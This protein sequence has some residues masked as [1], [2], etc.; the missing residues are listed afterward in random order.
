MCTRAIFSIKAKFQ[1]KRWFLGEKTH[2]I[3]KTDS[4]YEQSIRNRCKSLL[5]QLARN[6][7]QLPVD[8]RHLLKRKPNFTKTATLRALQSWAQR[9]N[10]GISQAKSG[11]KRSV[12]DI[13]NWFRSS[14]PK[15]TYT[16][17]NE[18]EIE[19]HP[20]LSQ[21]S[22]K[23]MERQISDIRTVPYLPYIPHQNPTFTRSHKTTNSLAS[24]TMSYRD[25]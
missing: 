10:L 23:T 1:I 3:L 6:P 24:S 13:R 4:T 9:V 12:S 19:F 11:Q 20:T 21:R 8:S 5:L 2:D 7:H 15:P 14:A 17:S 18:V 22:K 16:F 25:I